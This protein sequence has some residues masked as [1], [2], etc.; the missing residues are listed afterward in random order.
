MVDSGAMNL[1]TT[2][3]LAK[4]HRRLAVLLRHGEREPI[5]R[6]EDSVAA[7][8]NT[9]GRAA[10]RTLGGVLAYRAPLRCHHSPVPRCRDTA[11]QIVAGARAAGAE[12]ER[13]GELE[14]LGG[15]YMRDWQ[16][17]MR[18]V[19]DRGAVHLTGEWFAGRLPAALAHDAYA[20]ARQQLMVLVEQLQ[21]PDWRGCSLNVSHD[22]NLLLVRHF[23][24]GLGVAEVGWPGYLEGV[25]AAV[26]GDQLEL[27]WSDRLRRW[28][29]PLPDRL[30]D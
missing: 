5:E 1:P 30:P 19:L 12:A 14:P 28:P 23:F 15:P 10:A 27:R 2:I 21:R 29:L 4:R 18:L 16:A 8:L 6:V 7:P 11:E 9:A 13:I 25:A 3:D 20:S 26:D 22:W 17:V 24:L